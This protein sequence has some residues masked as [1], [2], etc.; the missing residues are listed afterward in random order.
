MKIRNSDLI[1]V[2]LLLAF[3]VSCKT[4]SK[5]NLSVDTQKSR[6]LINQVLLDN[7]DDYASSNCIYE[8]YDTYT[9]LANFDEQVKKNIGINNK[10]HYDSQKELYENFKITKEIVSKKHILTKEKK[11]ELIDR[12]VFID[13]L[14]ENHGKKFYFSISKPIFNETYDKAFVKIEK[15]PNAFFSISGK[16]EIYHLEKGIWRLKFTL[17]VW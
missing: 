9:I 3:S 16:D 1:L 10:K 12:N 6:E 14:R 5:I 8:T 4:N 17:A 11:Q 13:W 15:K 7:K 2:L